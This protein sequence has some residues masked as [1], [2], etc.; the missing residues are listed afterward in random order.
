[1]ARAKTFDCVEMK[2]RGAERVMHK[3]E[4][5]SREEQL[6]F[7]HAA[8]VKLLNRKRRLVREQVQPASAKR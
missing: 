7:W 1:M 5:M 4:G 2:R 8:H 6:A 3:L